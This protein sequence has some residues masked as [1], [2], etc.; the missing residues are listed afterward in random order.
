MIDQ[1]IK[2]P[3]MMREIGFFW[4]F[5]IALIAASAYFA[6]VIKQYLVTKIKSSARIEQVIENCTAAVNNNSEALHANN[7]ERDTTVAILREHDR[8]S[9][10]RFQEQNA[11][12]TRIENK[13][14]GR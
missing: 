12:L 4:V 11:A 6:P 13:L 2:N 7:D 9:D 5:V 1:L 8:A 3:D 10:L 14:Q